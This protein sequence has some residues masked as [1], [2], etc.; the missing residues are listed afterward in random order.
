M[1]KFVAF[2]LHFDREYI[3][4]VYRYRGPTYARNL[5]KIQHLE[6]N[7]FY[8]RE[9]QRNRWKRF[10]KLESQ[11]CGVTWFT[12]VIRSVVFGL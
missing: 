7:N 12:S 1:C 2:L 4:L 10:L 9:E 8:S 11:I 6:S 5:P 3:E